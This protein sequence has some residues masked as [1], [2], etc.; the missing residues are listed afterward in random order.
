MGREGGLEFGEPVLELSL[1]K[2]LG[3]VT[4]SLSHSVVMMDRS[5]AHPGDSKIRWL[6]LVK[7]M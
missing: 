4:Y 6:L 7:E 1:A 5:L 3:Q 2:W